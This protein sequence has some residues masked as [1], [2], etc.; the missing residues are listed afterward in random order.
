MAVGLS[1][2]MKSLVFEVS[3]LDP[4]TFTAAP[5]LLVIA[6]VVASYIPARRA[7]SLNPV[8]VLKSE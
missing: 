8:E 7:A 4:L 6:V 3:P 5:I 1:R 2:F